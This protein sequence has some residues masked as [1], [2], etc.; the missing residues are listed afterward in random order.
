MASKRDKMTLNTTK[1]TSSVK[2][3]FIKAKNKK[4]YKNHNKTKKKRTNE[5]HNMTTATRNA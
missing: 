3:T 2:K 4:N 1:P 5:R